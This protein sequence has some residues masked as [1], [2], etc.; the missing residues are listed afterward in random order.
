MMTTPISFI[1]CTIFIYEIMV[2]I[3]YYGSGDDARIITKVA[4]Y[5]QMFIIVFLVIYT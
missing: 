3:T 4:D 5:H 2:F 1:L